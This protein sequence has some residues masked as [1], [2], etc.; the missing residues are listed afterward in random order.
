MATDLSL[1][2]LNTVNKHTVLQQQNL[3]L[4]LPNAHG[5]VL[6]VTDCY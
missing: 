3:V 2:L 5:F 6:N 4:T 1:K